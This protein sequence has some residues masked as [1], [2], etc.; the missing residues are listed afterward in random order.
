LDVSS[1]DLVSHLTREQQIK[2]M[3]SLNYKQ[4][5]PNSKDVAHLLLSLASESVLDTALHENLIANLGF[6]KGDSRLIR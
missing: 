4:P 5:A 6:N 1:H 2:A 3:V